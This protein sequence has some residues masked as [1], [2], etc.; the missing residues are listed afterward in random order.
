MVAS[1]PPCFLVA[2]AQ[3]RMSAFWPLGDQSKS[4]LL[5]VPI[6]SLTQG[7][8]IVFNMHTSWSPQ[9]VSSKT[10]TSKRVDLIR[11]TGQ[12]LLHALCPVEPPAL[13]VYCAYIMYAGPLET[14]QISLTYS[15]AQ[16]FHNSL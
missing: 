6:V 1:Q 16:Q 5:H 12:L 8:C 14:S 4:L 15:E 11:K 7:D 9:G 2:P 13:L 3:H 10:G